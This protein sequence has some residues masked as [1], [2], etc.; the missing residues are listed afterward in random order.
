MGTLATVALA[1]VGISLI[2]LAVLIITAPFGYQDKRGFHYGEP[3]QVQPDGLIGGGKPEQ[4]QT[5]IGGGG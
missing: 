2:I 3:P 4:R 1:V 5:V